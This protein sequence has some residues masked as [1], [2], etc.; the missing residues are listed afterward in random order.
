MESDPESDTE[1]PPSKK[2]K[3]CFHCLEYIGYS[4]YYR[5]RERFFDPVSKQ[6]TLESCSSTSEL[7]AFSVSARN[8]D[9][10][11]SELHTSGTEDLVKLSCTCVRREGLVMLNV[12]DTDYSVVDTYTTIYIPLLMI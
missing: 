5:H 11:Q 7:L 6:W 2:R 10:S 12:R 1:A 3:Y 8:D 9:F 4:T